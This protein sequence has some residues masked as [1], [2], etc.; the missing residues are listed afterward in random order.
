MSKLRDKGNYEAII[1]ALMH[2]DKHIRAQAKHILK[3]LNAAQAID[4]ISRG[5]QH[6]DRIIRR[7]IADILEEKGYRPIKERELADFFF[8]R[9]DWTQLLQL[10]SASTETLIRGLS[11][12]HSFVRLES[13]KVLIKIG[14]FRA[15]EP[16]AQALK[17]S[18]LRVRKKAIKG[19]RR[20]GKPAL[21]YLLEAMSSENPE[22]R[23]EA[24]IALGEIGSTKAIG[25][26]DNAI[27]DSSRM[28]REAA[29][30]ALDMISL[31][32]NRK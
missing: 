13:I 21:E 3:S 23:E 11:D 26:L 14:D 17:D 4:A 8:A 28:V 1:E 20:L 29:R 27:S 12:K 22:I 16:F 2:N 18:D 19:L 5:L 9:T 25:I 32:R 7:E 10:G 24:A 15:A 31:I 30:K 6:E